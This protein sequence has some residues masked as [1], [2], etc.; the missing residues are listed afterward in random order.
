[1]RLHVR[2]CLPWQ[3][4]R[5][6]PGVF[7]DGGAQDPGHHPPVHERRG[8][9]PGPEILARGPAVRHAERRGSEGQVS[10]LRPR[11]Q[12]LRRFRERV[13]S[14]A[15]RDQRQVPG[16]HALGRSPPA[17]G[18]CLPLCACV[19]C[20]REAS[21]GRD[22]D[23]QLRWQRQELAR[24][25]ADAPARRAL[26]PGGLDQLHPERLRPADRRA[27][28]GGGGQGVA[29]C[30]ARSCQDAVAGSQALAEEGQP[31]DAQ[32]AGGRRPQPAGA[33]GAARRRPRRPAQGRARLGLGLAP[34]A[35]QHHRRP[36]AGG[37]G[38]RERWR[39]H[40]HAGPDHGQQARPGRRRDRHPGGL[41]SQD[42]LGEGLE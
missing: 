21:P 2:I 40:G 20:C 24:A 18:G 14:D 7:A 12:V 3:R 42:W 30:R 16:Q 1:M 34:L 29:G 37:R 22:V 23:R 28:L 36:P 5:A 27:A 15:G 4:V 41:R 10:P 35:P 38:A 11:R 32:A 19:E 33:E 17:D 31:R 39:V 6:Y 13:A 9:L 25:A 26:R 8:S